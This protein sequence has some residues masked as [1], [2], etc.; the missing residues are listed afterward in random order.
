MRRLWRSNR[1]Q[2]GGLEV[3]AG[4]SMVAPLSLGVSNVFDSFDA[5]MRLAEMTGVAEDFGEYA[6]SRKATLFYDVSELDHTSAG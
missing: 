6:A 2:E 4:A 1:L 3:A 5:V